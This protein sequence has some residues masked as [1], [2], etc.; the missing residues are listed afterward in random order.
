MRGVFL[1]VMMLGLLIAGFLVVKNLST[2]ET[3]EGDVSGLKA[4]DRAKEAAD[5]VNKDS[6]EM[7]KR[8]QRVFQD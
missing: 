3:L 8:L 4:M 2:D 1:V 7:N 5:L 6:E